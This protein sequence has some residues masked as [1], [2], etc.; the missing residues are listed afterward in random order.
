MHPPSMPRQ[1]DWIRQLP[2]A[3]LH[4]HLE[5]TLEP[6]L[7]FAL[8]ARNRVALPFRNV[9]EVRA[10]YRFQRLDDFLAIYYQG[11]AVL[12]TEQDFF[13]LTIEYLQRARAD[14]VCHV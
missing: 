2:K 6:E 4:L 11:T 9:E 13:D 7:M 12:Q 8:A 3:E 5:G 1:H 10:A 14:G